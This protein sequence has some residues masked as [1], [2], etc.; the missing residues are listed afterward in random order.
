MVKAGPL[1]FARNI[2]CAIAAL[3]LS[4][5]AA[6]AQS[7]SPLPPGP[8]SGSQAAAIGTGAVALGAGVIIA[9]IPALLHTKTSTINATTL[10]GAENEIDSI[11]EGGNGQTITNGGP[12]SPG[13]AAGGAAASAVNAALEDY[14]DGG[15]GSDFVFVSDVFGFLV[16]ATTSTSSTSTTSTH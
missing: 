11:L 10:T 3:L 4:F 15:A 5:A 2:G 7:L 9:G 8:A 12:L 13:G 6:S 14:Y 1:N 16:V